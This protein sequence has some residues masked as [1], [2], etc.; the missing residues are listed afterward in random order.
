MYY[1]MMIFATV[2]IVQFPINYKRAVE[3]YTIL[4]DGGI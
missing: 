1:G 4:G 3:M 2:M